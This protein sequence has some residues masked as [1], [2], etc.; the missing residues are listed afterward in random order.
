MRCGGA[1]GFNAVH[2]LPRA[3]VRRHPL[4]SAEKRRR[5]PLAGR[6]A[7]DLRRFAGYRGSWDQPGGGDGLRYLIGLTLVEAARVERDLNTAPP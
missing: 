2:P 3:D 4:R 7:S 5:L 6:L 1:G